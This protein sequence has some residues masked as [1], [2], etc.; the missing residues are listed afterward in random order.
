MTS[1]PCPFCTP[2]GQRIFHAGR[3]ILGL[4][5][6]FPVNPGHALLITKRHV[7]SWFDATDEERSELIGAIEIARQKILEQDQPDG[8]NIGVNVGAEAGQT[9]PHLHLHVIPRFAGDVEDPRGGVRWVVPDKGNY[10]KE[11]SDS[12]PRLPSQPDSSSSA[13]LVGLP[14]DR[15]LVSGGVDPLLAHLELHLEAATHVDMAVAF[16]LPSGLALLEPRLFD[17]L[18]QGGTLRILAGDYLDVTDPDALRQL[19]DIET[20]FPDQVQLK[21]FQAARTSFHPKAYIFMASGGDGVALV[22]SSNLTRPALTDGVE[23]NYRTLLSQDARGFR[24]V[25]EGF[26]RLWNH[27]NTAHL[28]DA[29]IDAYE[30]RRKVYPAPKIEPSEVREEPTTPPPKPHHIQREALEALG[31]TR[32]AGNSAGLVVLATGLGKTWL[33][34]FD[35]EQGN[36]TRVL[37]VAHREEILDQA[38]RTFRRIRPTAHLGLFTGKSKAPTADVLF[39]SV[40]A[41]SRQKNLERFAPDAFDYIVID[42]FHHAAART[43]RKLIDY[44]EPDFLLGLTATPERTDGG[45]LLALCQENLVYRCDLAQGI[46]LELL[47]PFKYFGVPDEVDYAQ[48]PWRSTRFDEEALTEAVATQKRAQN[49]LDQ[50]QEKGGTRTLAFCCSL[51]HANFMREFF[52]NQGVRCA[53]VHSGDGSD[54]RT[55]SLEQLDKGELDVVFAVDMFNEGVDLPHVDTIM[56]L[57]P[58]ESRLLWLQQFGRGLRRV[59]GKEHLRVIDYIG[60]H[61]IFLIKAQ[62][63]FSLDQ[64]KDGLIR[65]QLELVRQGEAD[66]PPGC[67]V[68][69]DLEAIEI[70]ESLLRPPQTEETLRFYYDDFMARRGERPRAVE[71]F[72]DGYN[73]RAARKSFGSWVRFIDHMGGL[74]EA[75][76]TVAKQ[77]RTGEFLDTLEKTPMTKSYKMLVLLAALNRDAFPGE[78]SVEDLTKAVERLA[79]RSAALQ[80]DLGPSSGDRAALIRHLEKN[81]IE[82]WTGGKGTGGSLFFE[83]R[84]GVF[85]STFEVTSNEREPFQELVRELADWRLAEYLS[86]NGSSEELSFEC[87]VSHATGRPILFLPDR[88]TTEGIPSGWTPVVADGETYEANFVKVAVNV[89]RQEGSEDN[90]LPEVLRSW[91]GED[92]GLPG[93]SHRVVFEYREDG[94]HLNPRG[95]NGGAAEHLTLWESYQRADLPDLFGLDFKAPVWNQGFV[96]QPPHLF[97]FVTLD[98]SGHPD[99]HKYADRFLSNTEFEWVSQNR[100][101]QEGKHGQMIQNHR[102]QGLEVPLFVRKYSKTLGKVTPFT[103]CGKLD[104]VSW[105][106]EKP[107][108]VQWKLQDPLPEHLFEHFKLD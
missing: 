10:L 86:R 90:V 9:V 71:A 15:A 19:L 55:R 92:A 30:K 8:F 103:Y 68:T 97:L 17:F 84:N 78:I 81:P 33:S 23:W 106:G 16:I 100:T 5:D 59:E 62:A 31:A 44:F 41:L 7:A 38:R 83:Y 53:A 61:R 75:T 50:H 74:D 35:T 77:G 39:A 49:A 24:D 88:A 18:Q 13:S 64:P 52:S 36:F 58:T 96:P 104:F 29:W 108:T 6:A 26:G 63:L 60:N 40:Q 34:A 101:T 3:L 22:G 89:M 4:W 72:H 99:E 42:E 73:P 102:D 2:D 43:Y 51:R 69:Y 14:H 45:D 85:R 67:E 80:A 21:V 32:T 20:A 1:T 65:R 12:E 82:A 46:E 98:K 107:V 70:L 105:A 47:S 48:I 87:K 11:P 54:P 66:L 27:P 95:R 94:W 56:M 28:D 93:T 91:F 25:T 37:F 57:R 76:A 79:R